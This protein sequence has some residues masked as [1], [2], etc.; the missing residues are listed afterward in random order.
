MIRNVGWDDYVMIL[1]MLL[2]SHSFIQRKCC[3]IQNLFAAREGYL[4]GIHNYKPKEIEFT[5]RRC[6]KST[7]R[8]RIDPPLGLLCHTRTLFSLLRSSLLFQHVEGQQTPSLTM[9]NSDSMIVPCRPDPHHP[10]SPLR[11]RATYSAHRSSWL[12]QRL[13]IEFH[14]PAALSVCDL[15]GQDIG[16]LLLIANRYTAFLS[17]HHYQHHGIHGRIYHRL[18]L[19]HCTAVHKPSSTVGSEREGYLL[20]RLHDQNTILCQCLV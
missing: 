17:A 4:V 19:H 10:W 2:V 15:F 7:L 20:E 9:A 11:R 5:R 6:R 14:H 18:L 3:D 1:A 16:R 13:Q 12:R 8:L